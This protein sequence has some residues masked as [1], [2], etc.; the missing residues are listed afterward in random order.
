MRARCHKL[1]QQNIIRY[2]GIDPG[3]RTFL[4]TFGTNGCVEYNYDLSKIDNLDKKKKNIKNL[5]VFF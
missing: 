4:T 3:V 2:C 1:I 5:K